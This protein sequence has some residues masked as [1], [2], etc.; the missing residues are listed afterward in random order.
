[1]S[2]ALEPGW[3]FGEV[4]APF[5][6]LGGGGSADPPHFPLA[7]ELVQG[8]ERRRAGAFWTVS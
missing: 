2:G 4:T 6:R 8:H 7:T 3:G 5:L 1:L